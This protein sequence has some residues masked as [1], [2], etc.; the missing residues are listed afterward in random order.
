M[1]RPKYA[2][3]PFI[4]GSSWLFRLCA[5]WMMFSRINVCVYNRDFMYHR[6]MYARHLYTHIYTEEIFFS[7]HENCIYIHIYSL[8]V[9]NNPETTNHIHIYICV[10]IYLYI[11]AGAV[12]IISAWIVQIIFRRRPLFY[13]PYI[14]LCQYGQQ[15]WA[16]RQSNPPK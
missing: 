11:S 5:I 4:Y 12:Q 7:A 13:F 9:A 10:Y 2:H 8:Y 15:Q 1:L 3:A 6:Y 14:F 16:S